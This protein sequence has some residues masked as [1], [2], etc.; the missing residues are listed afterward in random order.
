MVMSR[1]IGNAKLDGDL[2]QERGIGAIDRVLGK[3]IF[4]GKDQ[5]IDP[6]R[7]GAIGKERRIGAS[8]GVG[9]HGFQQHF[10]TGW[11][12]QPPQGDR[13]SSGGFALRRIQNVGCEFAIRSVPFLRNV[14]ITTILT[15]VVYAGSRD[16][17]QRA[18]GL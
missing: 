9:D 4:H 1:G 5:F 3:I 17:P 15:S 8:V 11:G 18:F 6:H 2:V 12:I 10:L 7:Q 13:Q 14:V 16:R